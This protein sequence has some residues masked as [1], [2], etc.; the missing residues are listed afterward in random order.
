[1]ITDKKELDRYSLSDIHDGISKKG[2]IQPNPRSSS[3][4]IREIRGSKLQISVAISLV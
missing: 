1:M 3:V 4:I 2:E